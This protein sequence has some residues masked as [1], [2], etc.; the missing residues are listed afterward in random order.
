MATIRQFPSGEIIIT[1]ESENF[2]TTTKKEF[3]SEFYFFL[4]HLKIVED[5]DDYIAFLKRY[6]WDIY[7][8]LNILTQT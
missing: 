5:W 2:N 7:P 4:K 6:K 1:D 3:L 8:I